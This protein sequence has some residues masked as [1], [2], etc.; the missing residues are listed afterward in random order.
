MQETHA[1]NG[2]EQHLCVETCWDIKNWQIFFI[3][4]M[5]SAFHNGQIKDKEVHILR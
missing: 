2:P 1:I 5:K 4:M 3:G